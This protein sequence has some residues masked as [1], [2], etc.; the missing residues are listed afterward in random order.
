MSKQSEAKKK[1]NYN[2]KPEHA[3]CSN[4]SHYASVVTEKQGYYGA[5][6][7]EKSKTCTFGGFVVKKTATCTEHKFIKGGDP[8]E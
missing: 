7:E 6:T 4:C 2:P 5:Y 8:I 3:M 1:Q